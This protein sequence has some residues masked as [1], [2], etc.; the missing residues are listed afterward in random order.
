MK[1]S[2]LLLVAKKIPI[3]RTEK[4]Y[5]RSDGA[6]I[7]GSTTISLIRNK[8]EEV[9]FLFAMVEDITLRKT[10]EAELEKSFSLQEATLESTADGILVV[11][12]DGKIV[13][14]QSEICSD[15]ANP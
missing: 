8:K 11:D 1:S 3:Y 2:L 6:V 7:W 9:Q 15:V 14:V 5:I 4:R 10:A 13:K 12:T